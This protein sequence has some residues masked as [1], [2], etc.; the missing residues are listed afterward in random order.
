[1]KQERIQK[2]VTQFTSDRRQWRKVFR[3]FV[4]GKFVTATQI[5]VINIADD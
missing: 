4:I 5:S 3:E 2:V 1:V